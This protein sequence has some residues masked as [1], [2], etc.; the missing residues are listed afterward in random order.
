MKIVFIGDSL[1]FGYGIE[2]KY[3]WIELFKN[4]T[5][6]EAINRG[7]SG[8]TTA[9]M[10][11]RF[12]RDVVMKN[13]N[14]AFIMGGSNDF[15][16]GRSIS[17]VL[18]NMITMIKDCKDNNIIP[19]VGIQTYVIGDIAKLYWDPYLD[20]SYVNSLI[21]TYKNSMINFC[22]ENSIAYVDFNSLL[23]NLVNPNNASSYFFDGLHPTKEAHKIMS[24][25]IIKLS[26]NW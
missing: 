4:E 20:Y 8:D 3:R 17:S 14:F 9:G 12:H 19:V 5:G 24:E 21:M 7:V 18:D 1:T 6:F 15:I 25:E 13:P 26:K 2:K 11:S 22:K 16:L 10:L 23:D